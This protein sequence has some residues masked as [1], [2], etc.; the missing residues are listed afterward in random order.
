MRILELYERLYELACEHGRA[1]HP[2]FH[3]RKCG[4]L[5]CLGPADLSAASELF[6]NEGDFRAETVEVRLVG[7]CGKCA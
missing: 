3:C 2:H 5:Y 6:I 1:V 4:S 7:L